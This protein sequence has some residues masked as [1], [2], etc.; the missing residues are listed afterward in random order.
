M[1]KNQISISLIIVRKE[2]KEKQDFFPGFFPPHSTYPPPPSASQGNTQ[3]NLIPPLGDKPGPE[4]V[5]SGH[6][7]VSSCVRGAYK[8]L[9]N[10]AGLEISG[11]WMDLWKASP[12]FVVPS[13]IFV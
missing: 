4:G 8:P 6:M 10:Y 7:C 11:P 3:N 12:A 9:L 5:P 2:E 1:D 13:H